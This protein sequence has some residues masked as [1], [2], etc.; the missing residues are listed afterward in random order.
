MK[1]IVWT[2]LGF[3]LPPAVASASQST[4]LE[5]DITHRMMMLAVQLGLIVVAA[6]LGGIL[7]EKMKIPAVLGEL[8]A[9]ML[10]GPYALG[11]LPFY[12]FQHGVFP[13][14]SPSFPVS[15]ELYGFATIASILLLF[16]VGLETDVN[17]FKRFYRAGAA[18]GLGGVIF[19]FGLGVLVTVLFAPYILGHSISYLHPSAL[20]LGAISSATSVGITARIL[21]EKHKIGSPE[22]VTILAGAVIDDVLGI[23]LLAVILGV[24]SVS[25]LGGNINWLDIEIIAVRA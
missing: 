18:V 15:P 2:S 1:K 12:G 5:A 14:F 25:Q 20:F 21:S 9:G 13:V 7:F 19:S 22:G 6:K 17:L 24:I 16:M 3:L 11:S 23:I 10:I 4:A 8:S